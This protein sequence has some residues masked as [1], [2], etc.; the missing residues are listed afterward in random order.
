MVIDQE[1][2]EVGANNFA[3]SLAHTLVKRRQYSLTSL[4]FRLFRYLY[5]IVF[6]L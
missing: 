4:L 5:H 2:N 6:L 3:L 1:C